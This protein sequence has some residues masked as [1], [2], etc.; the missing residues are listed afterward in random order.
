VE[1]LDA[2][3][4]AQLV[5]HRQ[6]RD[7]LAERDAVPLEP[8]HRRARLDQRPPQL[9]EQARLA[10]AGLA[11]E[12]RD[13]APSARDL[14]EEVAQRRQL[15]PATDERREPALG[16]DVEAGPAAPVPEH[17][18]DAD[19][20]MSLDRRLAEVEGLEVAGDQAM[21]GLADD[22]AARPGDLLEPGG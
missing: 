4:R 8:R 1:L 7:R 21:G 6:K 9:V 17:L 22:D 14:L 2:E 18:E 3:V 13:L 5:D 12:E 16:G 10:D 15:A 11:G 20:R 19:R